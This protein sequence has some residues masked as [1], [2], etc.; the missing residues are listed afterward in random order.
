M[1]EMKTVMTQDREKEAW[2]K[3]HWKFI[4]IHESNHEA[5]SWVKKL[6]GD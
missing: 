2:R 6:P 1:Q 3:Q 5:D 4:L